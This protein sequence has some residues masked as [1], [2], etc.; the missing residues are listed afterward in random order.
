[1]CGEGDFE[2]AGGVGRAPLG[3]VAGAGGEETRRQDAG[4]VENEEVAGLKELREVG[5]EVVAQGSSG[6][7]EDEHAAGSALG[8]GVLGDEL[9]GQVVMEVGDEHWNLSFSSLPTHRDES[10]MNG[11]PVNPP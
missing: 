8:G 4:V 9:G 5:E 1:V 6:A 3:A 7:V 11:A 2:E 10:A